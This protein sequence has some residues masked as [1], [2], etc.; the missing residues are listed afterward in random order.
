MGREIVY[1]PVCEYY[2]G[3]LDKIGKDEYQCTNCNVTWKIKKK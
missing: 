1:C 2:E 3:T